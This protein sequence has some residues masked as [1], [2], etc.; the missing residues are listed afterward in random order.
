[1]IRFVPLL[2]LSVACEEETS[3]PLGVT[4]DD[5]QVLIGLVTTDVLMLDGILGS[6]AIPLEDIG[7]VLPVEGKTLGDSHGHVTVWLRNGSELRGEWSEPELAVGLAVGGTEVAV[8]VPTDQ[9]AALQLQ[10]SEAWP[11]EG[12]FRARTTWGDDFLVDPQLTRLTLENELGV[13]SPFLSECAAVGPIGAPDGDWRIELL[14]GT[15]LQGPLRESEIA[16]ALP[17]GPEEVVVP[18]DKL[19]SLERGS[20]G[21]QPTPPAP[22]A[23]AP[24]ARTPPPISA[25]PALP[26][27]QGWFDNRRLQ[28]AKR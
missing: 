19:V 18:L 24:P 23:E 6:V 1:M 5:G 8:D 28:D 20:W 15:V 27:S 26:E 25:A 3:T 14:N 10:G 12:L 17:M 21:G 13:F 16:F 7:M 4:L 2:A 11:S 22:A 9:M